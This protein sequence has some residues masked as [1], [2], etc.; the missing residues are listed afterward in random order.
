MVTIPVQSG[1]GSNSTSNNDLLGL[2]ESS[3][4]VIEHIA[5]LVAT[6]LIPAALNRF[7]NYNLGPPAQLSIEDP[8]TNPEL[9]YKIS[10]TK[11]DLNDKFDE[12]HLL[13]TL[14]P[15]FRRLGQILL[16]EFD[17]KSNEVTWMPNGTLLIDQISIPQSNIFFIFP[18]LFKS[19]RLP[20]D[21][22]GLNELLLKINEMG[23]GHLIKVQPRQIKLKRSKVSLKSVSPSHSRQT[24]WWYLG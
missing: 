24:K 18:L 2:G 14:P 12:T 17:K 15:K 22:P 6:T 3:S 21:V 20:K 1:S 19:S 4:G 8:N 13:K 11:D 23:L 10:Q 7:Q 5:K 16:K 9:P